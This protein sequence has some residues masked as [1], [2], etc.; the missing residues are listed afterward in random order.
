MVTA[1][2]RRAFTDWLACACAGA[3]ERAARA[4]RATGTDLVT[5]VAFAGTAGHGDRQQIGED[6]LAVKDGICGVNRSVAIEEPVGDDKELVR[7]HHAALGAGAVLLD[8]A[9]WSANVVECGV[10]VDRRV[11]RADVAVHEPGLHG[12]F[13]LEHAGV[14]RIR[15]GRIGDVRS[16]VR[17]EIDDWL[18]TRVQV[19]E[20][21]AEAERVVDDAVVMRVDGAR[22]V[23]ER[24]VGRVLL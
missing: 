13:L 16:P 10:R 24:T 23:G 5:D 19:G 3:G 9:L 4:V 12:A 2:Y 7:L 22:A 20:R 11:L 6:H 1:A 14:E 15:L 21:P 18:Q 8:K 17:A